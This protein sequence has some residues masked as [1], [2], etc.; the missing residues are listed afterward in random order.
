[1]LHHHLL[2]AKL[3]AEVQTRP[4]CGE[5]KTQREQQRPPRQCAEGKQQVKG[6]AKRAGDHLGLTKLAELLVNGQLLWVDHC[7][8]AIQQQ[9]IQLCFA[10]DP[11]QKFKA[12]L[13]KDEFLVKQ[14]STLSLSKEMLYH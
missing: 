3:Q 10:L 14:S 1:M 13:Y 12:D 6:A 11:A 5:L 7:P 2:I 9:L 8:T 4:V